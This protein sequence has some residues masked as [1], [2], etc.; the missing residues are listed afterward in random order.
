MKPL[1]E[2]E[3]RKIQLGILDICAR[4][5]AKR[6]LTFFLY[7]GSL[8][9]AIRH[10]GFIPWDDD[11][12]LAMPRASYDRLNEIEWS[13]YGCEL[14]TPNN[15]SCSPYISAK[16]SYKN[17]KIL[18]YIDSP[19]Q[20]IG[21]SIDIFPIDYLPLQKSRKFFLLISLFII[22]NIHILKITKVSRTR[23]FQKN[24]VLKI[25]KIMLLPL[26]ANKLAKTLN[27]LAYGSHKCEM[28]GSLL[29]PYGRREIISVEWVENTIAVNFEGRLLPAP[30]EFDRILRLIYGNYMQ[31]PPKEKQ[32]SH[33]VF[34]AFGH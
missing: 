13:E 8:L 9:G 14:I 11:I 12:D 23:S 33:H 3:V 19:L 7:Y 15:H 21:V 25:S 22:R 6:D 27:K 31:L 1:A 5:F 32:V 16:L 28:A 26:S 2:L 17:S 18:D 4:E 29:G 20:E 30:K 24:I 10:E 34:T